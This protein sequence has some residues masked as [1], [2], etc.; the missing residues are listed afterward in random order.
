M[1]GER[2][3]LV[4]VPEARV[5]ASPD[6]RFAL[7]DRHIDVT[8]SVTI[9]AARIVPAAT[10]DAVLVSTDERILQPQQ[11]ADE[12]PP[13]EVTSDLRLTLGDKVNI[14]AYGLSGRITGTVRARSVPREPAVASGQLEIEDGTYSAYTRKLDVERGRLLFTGGP[15][16]DP[17]VDLRASR[18]LPDHV[19][20]VI[21][22]GR[23]RKPE[24][25]LYSEPPLPQSQIASMLIV[26]RTLDSLQDKDE[27]NALVLGRYLSPRLY[28]SYGISLV[29]EINTLKMRYT[30]GDRWVLA[31][32]SGLA[33]AIDIEYHIER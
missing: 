30:V 22:R 13:F 16:T 25:T 5:L 15:V 26:G 27:S 33:S 19:V 23:L 18:E 14:D 17:G 20:G 11:E 1:K 31:V 29:D 21:V 24:L 28:V 6:L 3:L 9:P 8:G 7:A 2:L 4:D 10:A 32:E 12:T